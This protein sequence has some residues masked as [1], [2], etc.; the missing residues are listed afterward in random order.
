MGEKKSEGRV[1]KSG[2][3]GRE[4]SASNMSSNSAV[5]FSSGAVEEAHILS[6]IEL[7]DQTR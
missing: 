4:S 3:A 2:S 1:S 7:E 6:V 5:N